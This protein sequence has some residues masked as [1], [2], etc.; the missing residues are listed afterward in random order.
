[1]PFWRRWVCTWLNWFLMSFINLQG[2]SLWDTLWTRRGPIGPWGFPL[3]LQA[4]FSSREWLSPP[5]R[6]SGRPLPEPSSRST[7]PA[8]SRCTTVTPKVHLDSPTEVGALPTTCGWLAGSQPQRLGAAK[9]EFLSVHSV[10]AGPGSQPLH[11]AYSRAVRG[12]SSMSWG[13]ARLSDRGGASKDLRRWRWS[14][15]WWGHGQ[16]DRLSPVRRWGCTTGSPNLW[17]V[18]FWRYCF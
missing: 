16:S 8:G 7:A 13:L 14:S 11:M 15:R 2:W 6:S 4:F 3:W 12:C 10:L 17:S 5:A 9:R 1:M 18:F